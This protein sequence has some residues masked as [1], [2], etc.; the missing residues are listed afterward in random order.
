[1]NIDVEKLVIVLRLYREDIQK[2]SD[3]DTIEEERKALCIELTNSLD[4][5]INRLND[6]R[7]GLHKGSDS[8]S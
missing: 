6:K 3:P 8:G 2:L 1:M 7:I 4:K 5:L